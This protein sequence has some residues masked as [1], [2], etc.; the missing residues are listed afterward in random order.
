MPLLSS[1]RPS[2]PFP[3]TLPSPPALPFPQAAN[4]TPFSHGYHYRQQGPVAATA[5][6]SPLSLRVPSFPP[7][8]PFPPLSSPPLRLRMGPSSAVATTTDSKDQWPLQQQSLRSNKL[9][10]DLMS[11]PGNGLSLLV[12]S[13]ERLGAVD[14]EETA[15]GESKAHLQ[16]GM[17]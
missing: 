2:V 16:R 9:E 11:P 12:P 8:S 17:A 5:A 6:I 7:T 3:C 13:S 4:G 14:E 10:L 1:P 15:E